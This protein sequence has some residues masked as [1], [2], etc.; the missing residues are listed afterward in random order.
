M[1][2]RIYGFHMA[3]MKKSILV[4]DGCKEGAKTGESKKD[5]NSPDEQ[6]SEASQTE[7]EKMGA[8]EI[9]EMNPT[10]LVSQVE[11]LPKKG[12]VDQGSTKN[13]PANRG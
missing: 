11:I 9:A 6:G 13:T 3:K 4:G 5:G 1:N 7:K 2:K 10:P 8:D 12:K